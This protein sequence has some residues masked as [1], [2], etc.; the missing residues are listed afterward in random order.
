MDDRPAPEQKPVGVAE[1]HRAVAGQ[2]AECRS[3][4]DRDVPA[5]VGVPLLD[6]GVRRPVPQLRA[7][8]PGTEPRANLRVVRGHDLVSYRTRQEHRADVRCVGRLLRRQ[9]AGA[10]GRSR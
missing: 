4:L 10:L 9:R 8:L 2:A 7:R 1:A 3:L 5:V 6:G